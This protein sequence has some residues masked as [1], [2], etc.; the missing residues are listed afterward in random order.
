MQLRSFLSEL[1]P[2]KH[3]LQGSA[4][5]RFGTVFPPR[6]IL[7]STLTLCEKNGFRDVSDMR[8]LCLIL[9][10]HFSLP[11][12][13]TTPPYCHIPT[14]RSMGVYGSFTKS[15]AD[16]RSRYAANTRNGGSGDEQRLRGQQIVVVGEKKVSYGIAIDEK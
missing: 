7:R 11:L 4:H 10:I 9:F 15:C 8:G 3:S 12:T 6:P 1:G 13:L 14:N 2:R 5:V 16:G